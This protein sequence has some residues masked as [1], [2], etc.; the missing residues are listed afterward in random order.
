M[1]AYYITRMEAHVSGRSPRHEAPENAVHCMGR[2]RL[3]AARAQTYMRAWTVSQNR[4]S[5][6]IESMMAAQS[7]LS[8]M[9]Q[10]NSD[11]TT[12]GPEATSWMTVGPEA[13]LPVLPLLP[14][15]RPFPLPLLILCPLP[16]PCLFPLPCPGPFPLPWDLLFPFPRPL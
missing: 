9:E 10:M 11:V 15:F 1:N 7:S 6:G 16:F 3:N 12:V 4:V 14:L 5:D 13:S 8:G 2:A